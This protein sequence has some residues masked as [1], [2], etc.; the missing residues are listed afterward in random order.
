MQTIPIYSKLNTSAVGY[1][2]LMGEP[3]GRDLLPQRYGGFANSPR[4]YHYTTAPVPHLRRTKSDILSDL[5][6]ERPPFSTIETSELHD[7]PSALS[8]SE[9]GPSPSIVAAKVAAEKLLAQVKLAAAD[10]EPEL[11][12]SGVVDDWS[13]PGAAGRGPGKEDLNQKL[14]RWR[15]E[16]PPLYDQGGYESF[17]SEVSTSSHGRRKTDGGRGGLFSCFGDSFGCECSII[18]GRPRKAGPRSGS[19]M[20]IVASDPNLRRKY[21]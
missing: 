6:E 12:S 20:P 1:R 4:Q 7:K 10:Q 19:K 14:E 8:D 17:R 5:G 3:R 16:L 21:G 9:I 11:A 15:A 13:V 18:C 2:A